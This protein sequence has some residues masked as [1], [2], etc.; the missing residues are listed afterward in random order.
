MPLDIGD[1]IPTFTSTDENGIRFDSDWLI[2]KKVV[3]IYSYPKDFTSGCW[4][5]A[6]DFREHY[7]DFKDLEAEVIGVSSDSVQSH[8]KFID[9]L[10][11]PFTLLS[12]PKD[13]LRH[14]FGVKKHVLGL[15]SG[16]QTFVVDKNGIL[17]FHFHQLKPADHVHKALKFVKKLHHEA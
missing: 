10:G 1:P 12:D 6:S 2:G 16:R 3:V 13:K 4:R 15:I 8:K 5:E 14:L 7:Q 17:C 9:R 11:L